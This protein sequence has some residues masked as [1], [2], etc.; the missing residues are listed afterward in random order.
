[1]VRQNAGGIKGDNGGLCVWYDTKG[2]LVIKGE[3][4][5]FI[6]TV[7]LEVGPV[8]CSKTSLVNQTTKLVYTMPTDSLNDLMRKEKGLPIRHGLIHAHTQIR[9]LSSHRDAH[10]YILP[11]W[12]MDFINKNIHMDSI[13]EDVIGWWAKAGWQAG[14]AEKLSFGEIFKKQKSVLTDEEAIGRYS[15]HQY[16]NF[17]NLSTTYTLETRFS[18]DSESGLKAVIPPVLAYVHPTSHRLIRRVDTAPLLRSISLQLAKLE[19]IDT[20]G[21]EASSPYAHQS[22]IA[23][24]DGIAPR[25]T[26]TK[27]D[28][29]IAENVIVEE[30]SSIKEC[31]IGANCRIKSGAKLLRCVLMDGV[32]I[33]RGCKLTGCILG[34]RCDIGEDCT[35]QDCE[36]QENLLVE[37]RSMYFVKLLFRHFFFCYQVSHLFLL[38]SLTQNNNPITILSILACSD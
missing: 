28:C 5:D 14:L 34:K 11:F 13:G 31:V 7:P 24:P 35:L 1:M 2:E 10:M 30:R 23:Y 3:E 6:A 18:K 22:K 19:S 26:V 9:M 37:A 4:T 8:P 33:G 32:V 16:V 38:P 15:G 20:I 29:I 27:S 25:T 12:V 21:R 17:G 36:V